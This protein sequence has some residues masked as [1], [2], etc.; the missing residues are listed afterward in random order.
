MRSRGGIGSVS[1]NTGRDVAMV[2]MPLQ[3]RFKMELNST[4]KI[5]K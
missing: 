4:K 5:N 3:K 1:V 2:N